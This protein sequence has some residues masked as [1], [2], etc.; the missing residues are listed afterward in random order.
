MAMGA[1]ELRPVVM[2]AALLVAFLGLTACG[3]SENMDV[4][5]EYPSDHPGG[6]YPN[7]PGGDFLE[8]SLLGGDGI[9]LFGGPD[10]DAARAAAAGGGAG[11]GVNAYLWRASLDTLSFMPLTS[12]D[13]FGGVIITDWYTPPETPGER[14]KASAFI[15]GRTL[16]ADGVRVSVF[17][18]IADNGGNWR[19]ASIGET[20]SS[21]LEDTILT[22]AR[23]LRI[24]AA[25]TE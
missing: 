10:Y 18:Q 6:V 16:R 8:E 25:A 14:F 24:R 20:V 13:P 17:R 9:V 12:A 4:R 19:D 21:D 3:S 5:A 2:L 23:Q 22:R 7:R 1:F 15:L 11:I